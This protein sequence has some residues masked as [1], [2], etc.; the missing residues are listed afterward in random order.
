[1]R[2]DRLGRD[3]GREPREGGDGTEVSGPWIH[4]TCTLRPRVVRGNAGKCLV[5]CPRR[6]RRRHGNVERDVFVPMLRAAGSARCRALT[7]LAAA[8]LGLVGNRQKGSFFFLVG[9]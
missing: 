7:P 9:S 6:D 2:S 4:G 1:M 5:S 3:P 8:E